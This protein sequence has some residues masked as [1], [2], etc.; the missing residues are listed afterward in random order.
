MDDILLIKKHFIKIIFE[1]APESLDDDK[2]Q[3]IKKN[4]TTA[5]IFAV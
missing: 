4:L 2:K 1:H 5:K 3:I